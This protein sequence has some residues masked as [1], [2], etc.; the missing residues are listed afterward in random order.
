MQ[1]DQNGD[2]RLD[3]TERRAARAFLLKQTASLPSTITARPGI[4]QQT[5]GLEATQPGEKL[6]LATVTSFPDRPAYEP[7]V[8]R[9]IALEFE[10]A[11]WEK[12][13][14]DFA[15]TDV[16]L[17]ATLTLD[18]KK[19]PGV[20]VRFKNRKAEEETGPGYKRALS[21]SL[22]YTDPE[23]T[24]NGRR[25][26]TLLDA[27]TD[28]TLLRT[29]LYTHVARQY[30][31]SPQANL[32]R[33][34]INGENWGTY[35]NVE[36]LDEFFIKENFASSAGAWWSVSPGGN[37]A[38]L[39]ANPDAYR[40]S[41]H[42]QSAESSE[43]WNALIELC[44]IID[45]NPKPEW[46]EALAKR[47]DIENAL[48]YFALENAL[49]NQDGYGSK[50]GSYGMYLG[51]DGRFRLIPQDAEVSFRLLEYSEVEK[52]APPRRAPEPREPKKMDPSD[53]TPPKNTTAGHSK[54]DFP[55]QAATDLAML[56]SYSF[57]NKADTDF[58]SKLSREEWL[59]FARSWFFV[60]DEDLVGK[61]NRDQFVE[62]FRII[63]TPASG[64]D[65]RTKQSFG[66]DDAAAIIGGDFFRAM[67]R[68]QDGF[69]TGDEIVETF[70]QWFPQW[71]SG[72]TPI[73]TQP[74]LQKGFNT[75]FSQTTFQADQSFIVSRNASDHLEG[76][77]DAGGK[78]GRGAGS[79]GSFGPLRF[80]SRG[81]GNRGGASTLVTYSAELYPLAGID[82]AD[83]PLLAK[84]LLVPAF[85]QQYLGYVRDITE[86]WL[87]W[88]KL[89]PVA[90]QYRDLI[91]AD[92]NKE[93]HKA[94]SYEHFVQEFDQD[95]SAGE[96]DGDAAPS[97]KN[98]V[99]ERRKF[100]LRDENVAN[101]GSEK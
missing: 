15:P 89:G 51:A 54:K 21:V 87:D 29:L 78:H 79:G 43:A 48:K 23:Q 27:A 96:R 50:E 81:R 8:L 46:E 32:L 11:D 44:K 10:D 45:Q 90:K 95:T 63:V 26:L 88:N 91:A 72:K 34:A 61:L 101:A 62:K 7:T 55:K 58:D 25:Q 94:N 30:I 18:G 31:Q 6:N 56:L 41:Y 9:T 65:G 60:M 24:W 20:G 57:V 98:F 71:A 86:N 49:I 85:R 5:A 14:A 4:V 74:A 97:L 75:L 37:L 99:V 38:Y 36:P 1:F 22:S 92:V 17:P 64:I 69:L 59:A 39:G 68:N 52:K 3:A 70:T 35:V 84:L 42:L 83:K 93:T 76:E 47:L 80:F 100:L 33:V 13:L 12:E 82:E 40:R 16:L 53:P 77:R 19:Y 73:I 2:H 67:D 28:A 66:K